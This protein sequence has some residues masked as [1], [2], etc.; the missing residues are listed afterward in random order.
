MEYIARTKDVTSIQML[1]DVFPVTAILGP[2]QV[3]K[4][5]LAKSFRPDVIF[6]LENPRDLV[7]LEQ[8]QLALEGLEGLIMIDEV[9]RKPELF[10]LIRFLVD[11][12][13]RQRY[14]LSGSASSPLRQQSSESLAGRIG[15]YY[16]T[17]LNTTETGWDR[18]HTLWLRGGF[19]R[20][21]L[22]ADD[23]KSMLWRNNFISTFLER[24]LSVLGVNIPAPV[25]YK[26][27]LMI[28]H[29]HGQNLNYS[30]LGRSFGISD[31]T[32]KHYLSILEDTFMIRLLMPWHANLN[33]RLVKSPKLYLRDSGIFHALQSLPTMHALNTSPK[34]GAS[35]EGFVLEELV[36]FLSKRDNE[37]F[38]YAA[39]SGV[40]LDLY[41]QEN[42]LNMGA[43]IKYMDAPRVT[44]S[45]NQ[46]M[47]DLSLDHLWVIYPGAQAYSLTRHIT[48]IPLKDL[49][50]ISAFKIA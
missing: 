35:W 26:F 47:E 38:Y 20:S 36:S 6:D 18:M 27:W 32:V 31:K 3:G 8:P 30:E 13:P 45:M 44:K 41:W 9:Q 50:K 29:Y 2:R 4:T 39:H 25:M 11:H 1:L 14:L 5:T 40:E 21:F 37:V 7:A 43:E 33:K 10:P 48:V 12:Y 16:L 28:S 17:G 49:G 23:N 34:A 19:P 22:A 46:A 42:G 24:D 15:Y